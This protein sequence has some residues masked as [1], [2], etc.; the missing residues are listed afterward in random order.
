MIVLDTDHINILQNQSGAEYATLM[1]RMTASVDQH[2]ATT[3]VTLE[4]HMRGW[5]ALIN[6]SSDPHRQVL[7]YAKLNAMVDY[8]SRWV[9]LAFDDRAA[10]LFRQLRSQRVRIGTMD[11]KIA[12]TT[13]FHGALLLSAN[14]RDFQ[15]VPNL[16]VEDWLH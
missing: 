1:A 4:E 8:F 16:Q 2:F 14:L 7:A 13:L 15:Q 12:A 5:L 9:R 11:L 3:T 10:D 6:R